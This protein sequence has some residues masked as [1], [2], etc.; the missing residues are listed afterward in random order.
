[1]DTQVSEH[2]TET[3]DTNA[4]KRAAYAEYEAKKGK[5]LVLDG[6]IFEVSPNNTAAEAVTV[7][8]ESDEI[9]MELIDAVLE[10][11]PRF[12][13]WI[14]DQWEARKMKEAVSFAHT[15]QALSPEDQAKV[16]EMI[17]TG[18]VPA[19]DKEA[20]AEYRRERGRHVGQ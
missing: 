8:K 10:Q 18:Q 17:E 19:E 16:R 14:A 13:E 7:W 6:Q 9:L 4:E 15:V 11:A 20:F 1:M 3:T 12:C 5:P 2:P